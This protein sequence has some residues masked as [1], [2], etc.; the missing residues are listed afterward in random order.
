M[1]KKILVSSFGIVTTIILRS[2][3]DSPTVVVKD[4]CGQ[5]QI[6][7]QIFKYLRNVLQ[8]LRAILKRA[9]P[10]CSTFKRAGLEVKAPLVMFVKITRLICLLVSPHVSSHFVPK[11]QVRGR[12]NEAHS[13]VVTYKAT[14]NYL[15]VLISLLNIK[16]ASDG[17][18]AKISWN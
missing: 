4:N 12:T 1:K 17:W 7:P 11:R 3:W 6:C 9:I 2:E 18:E 13:L 8:A 16:L 15:L 14:R 5:S 10:K